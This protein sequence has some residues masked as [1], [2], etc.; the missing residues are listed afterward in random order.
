MTERL[1]TIRARLAEL[2]RLDPN[3]EIFGANSHRYQ[4]APPLSPADVASFEWRH[5]VRLPED[6]R[7]FLLE[8]GSGGAGPYYGLYPLGGEN[9][10]EAPTHPELLAAPFPHRRAF[11]CEGL[12][13][14]EDAED[15]ARLEAHDREVFDNKWIAGTLTLCHEG[16]GMFD[17]L[18]VSGQARGSVWVDDRANG[19]GITPVEP[20]RDVPPSLDEVPFTRVEAAQTPFLDWYEWWLDWSLETTKSGNV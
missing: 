6:Y 9:E 7:A 5:G 16:C 10:G 2:A 13:V 4:L 19:G 15:E 11:A 8:V 3:F 18:I 20:L 12:D 1:Q 17:L 14:E